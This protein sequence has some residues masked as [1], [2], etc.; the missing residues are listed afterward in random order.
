MWSTLWFLCIFSSRDPPLALFS[1]NPQF[2]YVCQGNFDFWSKFDH[3]P[4]YMSIWYIWHEIHAI[5]GYIQQEFIKQSLDHKEITSSC[6]LIST[7]CSS[8]RGFVNISVSW[9]FVLTNS[10]VMSPFCAWS[11]RKWCLICI[12]LVLE[13]CTGFFWNI[14]GTC[15][16]TFNRNMLK[17]QIEITKCLFH[18]NNLCTT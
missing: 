11:L 16:I 12:C 17:S 6:L 5:R 8:L 3:F 7:N 2:F 18:P 1:W 13:C 10:S 4:K 9:S 14:Y 15:V